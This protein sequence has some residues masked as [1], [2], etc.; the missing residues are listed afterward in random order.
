MSLF[1]IKDCTNKSPICDKYKPCDEYSGANARCFCKCAG[2]DYWSQIVRCCLRRMYDDGYSGNVSHA[3]CYSIATVVAG[4]PPVLDLADC[5]AKCRK[6][7]KDNCD[8][9]EK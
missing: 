1:G 4:F 6:H 2:N 7:Q 9:P 8:C 3:V 5:Y